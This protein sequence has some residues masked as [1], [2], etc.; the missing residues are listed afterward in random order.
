M[1]AIR[2][3]DDVDI[4]GGCVWLF[5]S[6]RELI[7][8]LVA[9]LEDTVDVVVVADDRSLFEELGCTIAPETVAWF[10]VLLSLV[11]LMT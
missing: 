2:F 7:E 3:A 8:P 9:L 5:V 1:F 6:L 10:V 11:G 4:D